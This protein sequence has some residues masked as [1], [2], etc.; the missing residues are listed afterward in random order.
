[1]ADDQ[2]RGTTAASVQT[3]APTPGGSFLIDERLP[4]EVFTPEDFTDQHHLIAETTEQFMR[5]EVLPRWEQIEHQ[6]PGLTP[7]LLRQAGELGLLSIDVP[8]KYGG[9]ELDFVSS[10]I[11]TERIAQ[12]A[13]FAAS[14]G[15]HSGIGT[16]PI[17]FFGTEAQKRKYLPRL[18]TGEL[19]AAYCLS[20][21]EAGSDA[22][23]PRTCA[24]LSPDG[25][26]YLLNGEKMW[27]T[28]AGFADLFTVFAKVDGEKFSCFLVEKDSPGLS[29]GAEEK[30]MGIKGSSTRALILDNVPVPVENLV[31]EIGRGHVVAF[32]ILNVG[33]LKLAAGCVGGAKQALLNAVGYARQRRAFGKAIAEFGLIQEKLAEMASRIFVGESIVYRTAGLIDSKLAESTTREGA[34]VYKAI[35]EYAVECSINKVYGSE[36][37][38]YVT[39]EC[40][41]IFG[42][43]GY[44]QDYPAERAYRDARINRIFEGTNEINRL[45][46]TGMLLKRAT[47]GQLGLMATAKRSMEEALSESSLPAVANSGGLLAEEKRLVKAAKKVALLVAGAA[48]QK[49]MTM[50]ADQQ[51]IMAAISDIV[52][53]V[54]AMESVILRTEKIAGRYGVGQN[55][56][57]PW[58]SAHPDALGWRDG[59]SLRSQ[60]HEKRLEGAGA[61]EH[62]EDRA[63]HAATM[64]RLFVHSRMDWV[65]QRARIALAAIAAGDTLRIQLAALR[66]FTRRDTVDTIGLRQRIAAQVIQQGKYIV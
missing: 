3:R 55:R 32:N 18:A 24:T 35:E 10:S 60:S 50:L 14:F 63:A 17:V 6:E 11:A 26:H 7:K 46:I 1:M 43:Y 61:A 29:T 51:E 66:R 16:L 12:Y 44:H 57:R 30:K 37:L 39:D 4:E 36:I 8:E 58:S 62:A 15:A 25:K 47:S 49:Y 40:V 41:Q 64:S 38:D 34:Q 27:I 13:S 28:N 52:M 21:A 19:I 54:F 22:L 56:D 53:E 5:N 23:A 59:D 42:G 33:R 9:M 65:E 45:V 2:E 20:E 48:Y 31:G